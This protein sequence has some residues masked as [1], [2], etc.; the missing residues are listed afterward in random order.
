MPRTDDGASDAAADESTTDAAADG[1]GT[2][3]FGLSTADA[4]EAAVDAGEAPDRE[5]ARA[6]L[7]GVSAEGVVDEE[8]VE[9]ALAH[10][11]K[12]VSTPE[13]RAELAAMELADVREAA[14]RRPDTVIVRARIEAFEARLSAV[15]DAV[16]DLR[17]DLQS[18]LDRR[19]SAGAYAIARDLRGLRADADEVHR[20]ADELLVGAEEFGRWLAD[21]KIRR[22]AFAE[23]LAALEEV[24]DDLTDTAAA[25]RAAS[26][27]AEPT[28]ADGD[29]GRA[30][31]APG[32][33]VEHDLDDPA[34][35]WARATLGQ[36][37]TGLLL[38]DLRTELDGL[39]RLADADG[40][41]DLDDLGERIDALEARR[42][43][44]ES[45]LDDLGRP[46]WVD[47][48]G[49]RIAACEADLSTFDPPVSWEEVRATL[50]EHSGDLPTGSTPAGTDGAW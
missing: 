39:R 5:T 29:E 32:G 2:D 37:V 17:A 20:D 22:E 36:R 45:D 24:L 12:V 21:S 31:A 40:G 3:L 19:E 23:D 41:S 28:P 7:D 46:E 13:T 6:V 38:A 47:R 26:R 34:V 48:F 14:S 1:S 18:V 9:D 50:S 42:R 44:L 25:V 35:T 43:G 27:D 16:D 49:D 11:A 10:A 30:T 8:A 15:E 33:D 4:A